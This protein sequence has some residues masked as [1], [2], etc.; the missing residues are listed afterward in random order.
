MY[1]VAIIGAG[2]AGIEAAKLSLKKKFKTVIIDKDYD[3]SEA[4]T[5]IKDVSP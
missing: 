4:P 5:L 1:D 3:S 2:A